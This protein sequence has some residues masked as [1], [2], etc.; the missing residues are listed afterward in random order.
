MP[1]L[2]PF[3]VNDGQYTRPI[4]YVFVTYIHSYAWAKFRTYQFPPF[5][6]FS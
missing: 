6:I 4:F 1:L 2:Q 3:A 5:F